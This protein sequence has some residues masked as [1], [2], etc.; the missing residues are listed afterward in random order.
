MRDRPRTCPSI[1]R[2]RLRQDAL[3]S[4]RMTAIYPQPVY[5]SSRGERP[6]TMSEPLPA[7][8][9]VGEHR[10]VAAARHAD[11]CGRRSTG[12]TVRDPVC[13]MTVDPQATA[14][15]QDFEGHSYYFCCAGCRTR[16]A[17]DP[18]KYLRP[19]AGRPAQVL[20]G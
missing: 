12:E 4:L 11:H 16:F 10:P 17:A 7:E 15:R 1:R 9:H 18:P 19:D 3:M 8:H 2:N 5:G 20:H 13:G 14:H 6:I